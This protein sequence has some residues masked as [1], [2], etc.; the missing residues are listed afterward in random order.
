MAA[1]DLK[2]DRVKAKFSQELY[3]LV[4]KAANGKATGRVMLTV[5]ISVSQ[6]GIGQWA[7]DGSLRQVGG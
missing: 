1:N 5:E 4:E 3:A 7:V 6:G 2:V